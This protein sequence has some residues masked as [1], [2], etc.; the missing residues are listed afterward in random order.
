MIT[1]TRF[2]ATLVLVAALPAIMPV[3][4]QQGSRSG[5]PNDPLSFVVHVPAL[6]DSIDTLAGHRVQIQDARV[7]EVLE[8]R[9]ILVE[10]N[11]HY[12]TIRGQRDRVLVFVAGGSERSLA[13]FAVGAPVVIEGVARTLLSI[14]ATN[15]VPWPADLEAD[16]VR[17]LEV[18]GA[19]VGAEI[20]SAEGTPIAG[21]SDAVRRSG[22]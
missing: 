10:A 6:L 11:T 12:R 1:R 19:V 9:A 13:R 4:A 16:D 2:L 20:L 8:P 21:N 3:Q 7:L 22:I 15:E 17:E 14:R 18:R 5:P